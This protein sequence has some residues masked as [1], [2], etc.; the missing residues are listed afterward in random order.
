VSFD[1]KLKYDQLDS[2]KDNTASRDY[3]TEGMA[4]NVCFVQ[5]DGD[6]LF[7]AYGYMVSGQFIKEEGKIILGFTSH[8]ITLTGVRLESLFQKLMN[9]LPK[10]IVCV[11]N[12]YNDIESNEPIV[13]AIEIVKP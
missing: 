8:T 9:H 1:L 6:S 3:E 10:V 4:R 7:L 11:E 2:A 5:A 13:N 12:R